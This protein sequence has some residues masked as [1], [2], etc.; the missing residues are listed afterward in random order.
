[1]SKRDLVVLVG[2]IVEAPV[3]GGMHIDLPKDRGGPGR[4]PLDSVE[5]VAFPGEHR[6][7][8]TILY[9]YVAGFPHLHLGSLEG[10]TLEVQG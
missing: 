8:V 5:L 9:R 7:C 6:L 10:M 1:M 3:T 2:D 4:V